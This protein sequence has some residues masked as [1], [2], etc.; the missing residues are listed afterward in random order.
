MD[1]TVITQLYCQLYIICQLHVSANTIFGHHQVGYK[2]RRKLHNIIYY[3]ITT[4][5][6]VSRGDEILFTK[7]LEGVCAEGLIY[8]SID[9]TCID[10]CIYLHI[11]L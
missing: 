8:R 10:I 9:I 6:G 1:M 2:Y 4:S 3:S 5:V 11:N 7:E